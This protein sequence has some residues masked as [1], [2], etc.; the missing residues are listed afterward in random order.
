[1][2]GNQQWRDELDFD[3]A[4]FVGGIIPNFVTLIGGKLNLTLHEMIFA[5]SIPTKMIE[6]FFKVIMVDLVTPLFG[7]DNCISKAGPFHFN[8]FTTSS[9][10]AG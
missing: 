5:E 2:V 6:F 1:L 9:F 7:R 3:I 8:C 4:I 10:A